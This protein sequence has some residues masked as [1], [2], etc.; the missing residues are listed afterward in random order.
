[1]KKSEKKPIEL[2]IFISLNFTAVNIILATIWTTTK[3]ALKEMHINHNQQPYIWISK[4]V[5]FSF[6]LTSYGITIWD[7]VWH[8]YNLAIRLCVNDM[9]AYK[10]NIKQ[11][12]IFKQASII[13]A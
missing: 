1:M 13:K 9:E 4:L 6:S 3:Q 5:S 8:I 12:C 2:M 11:N 10:K 7:K